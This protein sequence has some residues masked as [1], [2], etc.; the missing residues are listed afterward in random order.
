MVKLVKFICL[1]CNSCECYNTLVVVIDK[2]LEKVV[3]FHNLSK[4]LLISKGLSMLLLYHS[5]TIVE[6]VKEGHQYQI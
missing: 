4:I 6:W 5:R 3:T 2:G 1:D